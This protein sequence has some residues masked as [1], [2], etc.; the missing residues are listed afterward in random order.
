[1]E[2]NKENFGHY[3]SEIQTGV[4][5]TAFMTAVCAF[6]LGL[7][8]TRLDVINITIKIPI[9]FLILSTFGFLFSTIIYANASGEITRLDKNKAKKYMMVGNVLSEYLG[10]YLLVLS[11][12]LVVNAVT[13]DV[14]LMVSTFMVTIVSLFLYS[15][16]P[17]SI[18]YRYLKITPKII[19][20]SI[21]V[22][23]ELFIFLAQNNFLPYFTLI[24]TVF[25]I[26][27]II[28]TY[29]FYSLE[30]H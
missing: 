5:F 29:Y 30:E 7:L 20:A 16:S 4:S 1:M 8:L 19:F 2:N 9:L 13:G 25:L 28:I 17:F 14:F 22:L 11:I 10:V 18:A 24:A 3:Q 15:I 6:F 12:P 23:F 21:V 26:F 27:I